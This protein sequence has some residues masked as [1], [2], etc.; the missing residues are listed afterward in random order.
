MEQT[1]W[2][3]PSICDLQS[4][5]FKECF[6][7]GTTL[8]GNLFKHLLALFWGSFLHL[9]LKFLEL[10]SLLFAE[11][12]AAG[13]ASTAWSS[14]TGSWASGIL[15]TCSRRG[16]SRRAASRFRPARCRGF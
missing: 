12:T 2:N 10:F 11:S 3:V 16:S 14:A 8:L 13:R 5:A 6:D 1:A 9:F 7:A 4:L 15:P